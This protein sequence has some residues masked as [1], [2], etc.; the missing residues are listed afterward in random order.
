MHLRPTRALPGTLRDSVPHRRHIKR[1]RRR[2]LG[3][4]SGQFLV[5]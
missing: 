2:H 3:H 1:A 5:R 4:E